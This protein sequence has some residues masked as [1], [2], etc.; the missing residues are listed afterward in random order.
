MALLITA[1][2]CADNHHSPLTVQAPNFCASCVS[3]ECVVSNMEYVR[4]KQKFPAKPGNTFDISA[5]LP[6]SVKVYF[7]L[8]VR[9]AMKLGPGHMR[10]FK[11]SSRQSP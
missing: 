5:E 10:H 6:A 8:K 11:I 3:E 2:F 7:L 4:Q 1:E 9:R